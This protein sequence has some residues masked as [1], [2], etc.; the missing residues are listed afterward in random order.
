MDA[1]WYCLRIGILSGAG[2]S[3]GL[4]VSRK[5]TEAFDAQRVENRHTS[6]QVI[7]LLCLQRLLDKHLTQPGDAL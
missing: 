5:A 2:V 1:R 4:D 7:P 3:V 6:V